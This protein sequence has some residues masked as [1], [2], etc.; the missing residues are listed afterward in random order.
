VEGVVTIVAHADAGGAPGRDW[1]KR[2]PPLA[3]MAAIVG[4]AVF[5]L[6]SALNLPQ[7]NPGEIAEYAPVPGQST[8]AQVNGNFGGL[9]QAE[10]G[11]LG[12]GESTPTPTPAS[13]AGGPVALAGDSGSAK[14]PP[15][16]YQCVGNPPRQT[17]DPL[18]PPCVP[19]FFGSNGGSTYPGVTA[20]EITVL[21]YL[22]GGQ[23][24]TGC[25][26][27]T[28]PIGAYV[29]LNAPPQSNEGCRVR[30]LRAWQSYF[31]QRYQLYGRKAHFYIY[32]SNDINGEAPQQRTAEANDNYTTLH[33]FAALPLVFGNTDAYETAMSS[34]H[35]MQFV[36]GSGQYFTQASFQQFAPLLWGYWPAAEDQAQSE[37]SWICA[38]IVKPGT[39]TFSSDF[40]GKPRK[41][42]IARTTDNNT[43]EVRR[44]QDMVV[45]LLQS[46]CGLQYADTVD[47]PLEGPIVNYTGTKATAWSS[48]APPKMATFKQEGIT[49]IIWPGGS[50]LKMSPAAKNAQYFPEWVL[51]GDNIGSDGNLAAA[52]QDQTEWAQAVVVTP[53]TYSGPTGVP[54]AC[55]DAY[56]S[57]DP[58]QTVLNQ[59]V[60]CA[61]YP[62]AREL[63]TG[64]QVAGPR[65]TPDNVAQGYRAIPPHPSSTASVPACYY[66]ANNYT[67]VKDATAEH[68]D[69]NAVFNTANVNFKGCWRMIQ[70]GKRYLNGEWHPGDVK[71]EEN[72][73]D[74]CNSRPGSVQTWSVDPSTG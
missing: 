5:G 66:P 71:P 55:S 6:P 45:S 26:S 65:L 49:T 50:D 64:I 58:G 18:A 15:S 21:F 19:Y 48:Y 63:F 34:H 25:E 7:A 8:S 2:Y 27:Q 54:P 53:G 67:C 30:A 22:E 10:G 62:M 20:R 42:A 28:S 4:L 51:G 11:G 60:A 13:S 72:S 59:I 32:W 16:Q 68:W 1:I 9:G 47:Y 52:H 39:V 46:Q 43:P 29:D 35:V 33:P 74:I 69:P 14:Q 37:A 61:Y 24:A 40:M 44:F 41:Y 57:V 38:K 73:N 70:N 3:V 31:N 23:I 56:N 12:Q 36:D 17:E